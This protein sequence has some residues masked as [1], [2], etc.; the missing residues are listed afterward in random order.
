MN[1]IF[2][3]FI[4]AGIASCSARAAEL[5]KAVQYNHEA[6]QK[7]QGTIN[8]MAIGIQLLTPEL[9]RA[10]NAL[11]DQ[12]ADP[13]IGHTVELETDVAE[14]NKKVFS[15]LLCYLVIGPALVGIYKD[16]DLALMETVT[17]NALEHGADPNT[18]DDMAGYFGTSVLGEAIHR[19]SP[20]QVKI[21][22]EHGATL[23]G[24]RTSRGDTPEVVLAR[25]IMI[26]KDAL[27]HEKNPYARLRAENDI[28]RMEQILDILK[29]AQQKK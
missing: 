21:L 12:G 25:D 17:K 16:L 27:P 18:Q 9:L 11:I 23:S 19:G 10:I 15:P 29:T 8:S 5:K 2:S 24:I 28:T 3:V 26:L 13:N 14:S 4:L 20:A 6:T 7:L 22:L 1:K